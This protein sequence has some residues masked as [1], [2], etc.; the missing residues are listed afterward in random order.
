MNSSPYSS[1]QNADP[2]RSTRRRPR[3][4]V[5][6]SLNMDLVTVTDII[7]Q[8]GETVQGLKFGTF[9]GGKGANQAVAAARLGAEVHMIGCVGN[10]SFGAEMLR[11]LQREGI[12]CEGVSAI[13]NVS[14]GIAAITIADGDNRIIVVPGANEAVT[15]ELVTQHSSLIAESDLVVLQLEIPLESVRTAI[16]IANRHH[17]PVMLN[18]AP[19]VQLDPP[20]LDKISWVTPNEHELELML[21]APATVQTQLDKD[22][23]TLSEDQFVHTDD[24]YYGMLQQ[25][26]GKVIMTKGSEGAYWCSA[27]GTVYHSPG[28]KVEVADT[29]GAGDTFNGALAVALA[30]KRSTDQAI[31]WAVAAGALSVTRF[32]AQSGMP[33]REQLD[34]WLTSN[35]SE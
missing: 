34:N 19:A 6:G 30:E 28:R 25:L 4:T 18:P 31:A 9:C 17:I 12:N 10:D 33:T 24:L 35:T 14:S 32:G 13:S 15:N 16:D 29:T 8:A 27:D 20:L 3:I 21:G 5:I 26:P 7:P 2:S 11:N 1:S 22:Q 23:S